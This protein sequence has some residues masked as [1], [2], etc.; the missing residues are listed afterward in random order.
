LAAGERAAAVVA[1]DRIWRGAERARSCDFLMPACSQAASTP[2]IAAPG[3]DPPLGSKAKTSVS[4]K[5]I[6]RR[7]NMALP[8]RF[9]RCPSSRS[10][11]FSRRAAYRI[12]VTT[13]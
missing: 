6:R 11:F 5:T 2:G 8:S 10:F 3:F 4:Q 13:R 12:E 1:L 9:D 7:K